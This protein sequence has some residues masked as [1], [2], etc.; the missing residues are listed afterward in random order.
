MPIKTLIFGWVNEEIPG[1]PDITG[2]NKIQIHLFL[3][4]VNEMIP[5]SCEYPEIPMV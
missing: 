4:I 2:I 5:E 3:D 1:W